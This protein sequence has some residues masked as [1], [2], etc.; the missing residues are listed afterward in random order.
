MVLSGK[1]DRNR[2]LI[3]VIS[4]FTFGQVTH[5]RYFTKIGYKGNKK[6]SAHSNALAGVNRQLT[7]VFLVDSISIAQ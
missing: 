3:Y 2:A 7:P 5:F 4:Y 1:E 6:C